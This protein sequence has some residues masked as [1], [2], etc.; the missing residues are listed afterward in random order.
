MSADAAIPTAL[1]ARAPVPGRAKTRL[2]PALGLDGAAALYAAFLRD[3]LST[4]A[5]RPELTPTLWAASDAD[6]DALRDTAPDLAL[7][8]QPAGDLGVRMRA[9]LDHGIAQRGAAIVVGTDVPTLPSR[10]VRAAVETLRHADVV[11]GPS[12]DGGYWLV[13]ARARTFALDGVR[14]STAHALAD[15]IECARSNAR[16]VA[17]VPPWYD[18]DTPDDLL[19]LRTHLRLRPHAAPHTARAL[20]L[21]PD[22]DD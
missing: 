5:S 18:V 8:V 6:V 21:W 15:T 1:F 20:G 22:E 16:S 13:G 19:L 17:L 7:H 4:I 11:L 14:W 9:A 12:A 3:A 10:L 2:A